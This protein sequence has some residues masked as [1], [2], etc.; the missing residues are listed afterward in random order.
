MSRY[1]VKYHL[2]YRTM[3]L[4]E[5][6]KDSLAPVWMDIT[7]ALLVCSLSQYMADPYREGDDALVDWSGM[8]IT[9]NVITVAEARRK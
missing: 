8:G 9:G 4:D 7:T 1:C 5:H 6:G 2:A 3:Y